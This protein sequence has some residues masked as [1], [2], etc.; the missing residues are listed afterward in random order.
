MQYKKK[1]I[2]TSSVGASQCDV[3]PRKHANI[4]KSTERRTVFVHDHLKVHP[5]SFCPRV[6]KNHPYLHSL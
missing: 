2:E 4:L 5:K 1:A 6:D 3:N